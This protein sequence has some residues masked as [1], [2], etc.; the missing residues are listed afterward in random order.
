MAKPL[1]Q[2]VRSSSAEKLSAE[3]SI[4]LNKV[5]NNS[6][7]NKLSRIKNLAHHPAF[8]KPLAT[9]ASHEY[10]TPLF[11]LRE[12]LGGFARHNI[13]SLSASLSFYAL[14]A[15]IPLIL[16]IFF[17]LSHLVFSSDYAIVKLAILTGNLVPDF[18][19]KIMTEV[20]RATQTKAAWGALGIFVLLWTV[21]PLAA[22]MR[23][24]FYT[25]ATM[26]EAPSY[27]KRKIKDVLS[28]LGIL[29]LFFLFT[30]AGF[31]IEKVVRFLAVHLPVLEINLVG[32]I[33]TLVLI[34]LLIA[35]FYKI[36]F[37]MRIAFAHL[38]LGAS[39]TAL[40][41]ILM[42]PA[43][44]LFLSINENYG[45][46]FGSM[47]AM[48]VSITWLY[49]NFAVFLLGI[50]LIA[51]LRKK[52]VLLLKGLFNG[53]PNKSNYIE[54]LMRRYGHTL[55]QGETIYAR[56]NTERN[57]Y[58]V[59]DGSVNLIDNGTV[60][61]ELN[62]GDYFGEMAMLSEKPTMADAIVA[63]SEARII[64]IYAEYIDTMMAD[65]PRVA[66]QLL[67]RMAARL[68]NSFN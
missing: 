24:A 61:R 26:V 2:D 46:I 59:V 39:L 45:A 66:V 29:L 40:L 22:N 48:F 8:L 37:P 16:L 58:Y 19:N 11:I 64:V 14:F 28:V 53:M 44:G 32:S 56:G 49:L 62:A 67:K 50:E 52:D 30:F 57:L 10:A 21:T 23:S 60:V 25:I 54:T 36:F 55:R 5:T 51:T 65:E 9:Y 7:A 4:A 43:F 12:T 18:S 6:I 41:W 27:F 38:F 34:T 1:P 42:R 68:Q 35:I 13:L 3:D 17:L 63:S 20:Y 31:M 47:K 15:L 33:S